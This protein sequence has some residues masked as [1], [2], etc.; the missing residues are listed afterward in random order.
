M[1]VIFFT[2]EYPP[3]V[4]GGAGVHV[5]QLSQALA[6]LL[7]VEVRTF[8]DQ[9]FEAGK[10]K[11]KGYRAPGN[12]QTKDAGHARVLSTF[13]VNSVLVGDPVEGNLVHSHTW[14]TFL[15]GFWAK[16]LYGLP[17]VVTLHSL[18]PF[19][20]WKREQLGNAYFLSTW[21]EETGVKEADKVIAVSE[22]VRAD[23]IKCYGVPAEKV[24]VIYNG[25]D[26]KVYRPLRSRRVL[27]KFGITGTYILFVGRLAR[28]KGIFTL[29]RAVDFLPP[30]V[31]VVL[32]ASSPDTA[33]LAQEVKAKAKGNVVWINEML[34]A[35]E[36]AELYSHA[37]V[38]VC[39]SIY[40]PFGLT[41]LEA[42]A[43]GTPVVAS[44]VGGIKEIILPGKNGL[45]VPPEDPP[46]LA[47]AINQLL[48]R[49][50]WCRRL[51]AQGRKYVQERFSWEQIAL[52]TKAFYLGLLQ[53]SR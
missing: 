28:Q 14:Y 17:L 34:P 36:V 41:N 12:W 6:K 49:P 4:Y 7:E 46:A 13:A 44:A 9:C 40:E 38:F 35:A 29:L 25:V 47:G 50:Q 1:K 30:E 32:C 22:A 5:A 21:A 16:K 18:E 2:N 24:T 20:P 15:A 8:G 31:Q 51:G 33:E 26:T 48:S 42:L 52:Q 23:V 19:R 45:L 3:Y 43:C 27:A 11:E 53:E 39:P 37:S 10:L